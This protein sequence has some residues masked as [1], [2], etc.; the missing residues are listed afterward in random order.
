MYPVE[1]YKFTFDMKN[2]TIYAES[3]YM[4]KPVRGKAV[5]ALEDNFDVEYGMELAAARCNR[6]IA[7]KRRKRA[8]KKCGL[9]AN[10]VEKAYGEYHA[11]MSY[12]DDA[13]A[14][15]VEA[16]THLNEIIKEKI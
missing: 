10:G 4:G 6:K 11:M 12:Y 13:L 14:A 5:A 9:A 1:K 7:E 16:M 2:R 15:E 8:L 3:T